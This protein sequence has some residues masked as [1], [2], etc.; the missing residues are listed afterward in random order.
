MI[1]YAVSALVVLMKIWTHPPFLVSVLPTTIL[2]AKKISFEIFQ[3]LARPYF[4]FFKIN[5][6]LSGI[7][8]HPN[9]HRLVIILHIDEYQEIFTFENN[10]GLFKEMMLTLGPLMTESNSE[11][12]VQTFLSGT[13]T[14]DVTKDFKPTE[15]SFTFVHCP[16]L[17]TKSIL[18][19]FDFFAKKEDKEGHWMCNTRVLQL[20]YDTSGLPRALET[21]IDECFK[22]ET[23]FLDV[24]NNNFTLFD[25]VFQAVINSLANQYKLDKFIKNNRVISYNSTLLWLAKR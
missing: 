22:R 7:L 12:Y 19:I 24:K 5:F 2:R 18:E 8:S 15:Y 21:V 11:Y 25:D 6:V 9:T 16:L 20:L 1:S 13:V 17:S 4:D 14:Q 3:T 23:F 10:K